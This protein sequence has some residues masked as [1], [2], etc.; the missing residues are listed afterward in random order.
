MH[1]LA[2]NLN[3]LQKN[4]PTSQYELRIKCPHAQG[5]NNLSM[6]HHGILLLNTLVL[7]KHNTSNQ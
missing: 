7:N 2:Q 5:L 6:K 1:N 3:T 4:L